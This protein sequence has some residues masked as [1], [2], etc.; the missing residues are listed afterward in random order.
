MEW[1]SVKDRLPDQPGILDVKID[2]GEEYEGFCCRNL[3]GEW[4][5]QPWAELVRFW[6]YK[7]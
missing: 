6:K 5:I 4:T 1:I 3:K 2:T 7:N